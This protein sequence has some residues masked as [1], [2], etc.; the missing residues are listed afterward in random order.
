[1]SRVLLAIE[2]VEFALDAM[3]AL[4]QRGDRVEHVFD[5]AEALLRAQITK[6]DALLADLA[7]PRIDHALLRRW[8]EDVDVP[9][10]LTS[11]TA[12]GERVARRIGVV[13]FQRPV[14]RGKVRLRPVSAPDTLIP[15]ALPAA[16]R[17]FDREPPV[18]RP[19]P[20]STDPLPTPPLLR[21][22]P[23]PAPSR[24][25]GGRS[26]R[27]SRSES[28]SRSSARI[29]GERAAAMT[30]LVDVVETAIANAAAKRYLDDRYRRKRSGPVEV[31]P[32]VL[33]AARGPNAREIISA[34]VGSQLGLRCLTAGTAAEALA[35]LEGRV[36]AVLLECDLLIG[37]GGGDLLGVLDARALPIVPLRVDPSDETAAVGRAA[38]DAIPSLRAA[39]KKRAGASGKG[40]ARRG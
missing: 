40:G 8:A 31:A 39:L 32:A 4:E 30:V 12:A 7:A 18:R 26:G 11:T 16:E 13:H 24:N 28:S 21:T 35:A 6:P 2:D 1:M 33:V 5:L 3:A 36:S 27:P 20:R 15:P 25:P 19:R 9:L 29:D 34:F 23:P 14:Y 22:L 10:I 17:P 37:P 38:W